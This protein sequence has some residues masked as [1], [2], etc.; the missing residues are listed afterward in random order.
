MIPLKGTENINS[1]VANANLR[2]SQV[3]G[4]GNLEDFKGGLLAR[5]ARLERV[6]AETGIEGDSTVTALT[7]RVKELESVVE[8]LKGRLDSQANDIQE[9]TRLNGQN[10]NTILRQSGQLNTLLVEND[11]YVSLFGKVD[12]W[13]RQGEKKE[14]KEKRQT[15][16][17]C[18]T[19]TLYCLRGRLAKRSRQRLG[20]CKATSSGHGEGV[21]STSRVSRRNRQQGED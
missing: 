5:L 11:K 4:N 1:S 9:L 8:G 7:R 19:F 21:Q 16:L 3:A 13:V 14:R 2:D 12:G 10:S 20:G 18:N 6:Q 17:S 15:T